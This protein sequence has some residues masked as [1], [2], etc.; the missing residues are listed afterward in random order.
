MLVRRLL[1]T[2]RTCLWSTKASPALSL[3]WQAGGVGADSAHACRGSILKID[4]GCV[5]MLVTSHDVARLMDFLAAGVGS[6]H[7]WL[8]TSCC[9]LLRV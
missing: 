5:L 1:C 6:D 8:G 4:G 9:I 3:L 2:V 7:A